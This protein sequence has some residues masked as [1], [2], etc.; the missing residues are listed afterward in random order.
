MSTRFTLSRKRRYLA[1]AGASA[2]VAAAVP[3]Q[4]ARAAAPFGSTAV[5][6]DQVIALA[7][8]LSDGRWTLIVLE[9][10]QPAPP[11]WRRNPDGS[12][13]TYEMHLPE[14]TCGRYLSS[15]AYS[16]RVAGDDLRHPWRLRVESSNGQLQLLASG[17]QQPQPLLL[18]AGQAAGSALVEL[19][20][21]ND[22]AFERRTYNGQN[23]S[24]LYLA[25]GN[26]LPVLLAEARGGT[27]LLAAL[28]TPPP[29]P[30][31]PDRRSAPASSPAAQ[32]EASSSSSSRLAR[33]ESLRFGRPRSTP[34]GSPAGMDD[35]S[36]VIALQVVP[37]RP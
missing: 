13:L 30:P 36:G 16:L 17:S 14:S 5:A 8:P 28:P 27:N 32:A 33:L 12:V 3:L 2:L 21:Q 35:G 6:E 34:G 37:F 22:W 7:Q 29:P 24:H 25:H 15:S 19:K 18:G 1:V 20:L 9:Q 23:L 4:L 26:P 31:T 11:C 10:R